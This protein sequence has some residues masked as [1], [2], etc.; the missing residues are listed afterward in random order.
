MT[1][2]EKVRDYYIHRH[3]TDAHLKNAVQNAWITADD[4]KDITG[5]D[6]VEAPPVSES[7]IA[8]DCVRQIVDRWY[9]AFS[10]LDPQ[11]SMNIC[12]DCPHAPCH[13]APWREHVEM[14]TPDA[15][16]PIRLFT[17]SVLYERDGEYFYKDSG[18]DSSIGH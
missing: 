11:A 9:S 10:E 14:C 16:L 17:D 1:N 8:Q 3:W 12:Y 4:Y 18:A 2:K 7:V 15:T 13:D 5:N 6:Y